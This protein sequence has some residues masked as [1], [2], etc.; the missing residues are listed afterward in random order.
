M[1]FDGRWRSVFRRS[2]PLLRT[3]PRA[4]GHAADNP[5]ART[6]VVAL[7]AGEEG[8]ANVVE[9]GATDSL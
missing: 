9:V 3:T 5:G 2:F 4:P 8:I 7:E 6:V 1:S